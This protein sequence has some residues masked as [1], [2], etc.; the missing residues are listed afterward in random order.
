MAKTDFKK[1][2]HEVVEAVGGAGN[3]VGV[4]HCATRLRFV[5]KDENIVDDEKVKAIDGVLGV[6]HGAGQYQTIIGNRVSI[7]YDEIIAM[8]G[9]KAEGSVDVVEK[10]DM[11][12]KNV[13][14]DVIRSIAGCITPSIMAMC[15]AGMLKGILALLTALKV[16][17]A[18][19]GTYI[20]LYAAADAVFRYLPL[21]IA[22]SAAK[23][24]RCETF[25][26]VT[27]VAAML[28]P[29]IVNMEAGT[30]FLGI[31][32]TVVDYHS[33]VLP[34]I[35]AVFT[36]AQLEKLLKKIVPDA[37][38]QFVMPCLSLAIMVPLSLLVIGPA[39]NALGNAM[40]AL[41]SAVYA[42][43][44]IIPGIVLGGFWQV[45]VVFGIHMGFVPFMM[46]NVIS[47][48]YDT[49]CPIIG[50]S[51]FSIPGATLGV[52]LK[53]KNRQLK[54]VAGTATVSGILGG[55]TEPGIYG[56][57]LPLKK[58]MIAAIIGGSLGGII[59]ALGGAKAP[60]IVIPGLFTLPAFLGEGFMSMVIGM[61]VSFVASAVISYFLYNGEEAA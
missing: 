2:A 29:S 23:Q 48:G 43:S 57:C 61:I 9:I 42:I 38:Y 17:D 39:F 19:S 6:A 34:P 32:L 18:A 1:L 52:L 22:F 35:I 11:K 3:I 14:N 33:Q 27:I 5:L 37:A 15:G 12:K 45:L 59:T 28:Y 49:M 58:P 47:L 56:V 60:S 40:T 54:S 41:Y 55:I 51:N 8:P 30:K 21:I 13:F 25:I 7:A 44:P 50:P 31:P 10:D 20:V 16:L 26:A 53:T 36:F 4:S 24:F 46:Q